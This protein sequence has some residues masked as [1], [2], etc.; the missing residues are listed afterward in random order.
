M[1][2]KVRGSSPCCILK[3]VIGFLDDYLNDSSDESLSDT[4]SDG[5]YGGGVG[6]GG[7]GSVVG[8][9]GGGGIRQWSSSSDEQ[10]S[11]LT[12]SLDSDFQRPLFLLCPKCVLLRSPSPERILLTCMTSR[13]KAICGKWHSLGSW[14]RAITG[15][16]RVTSIDRHFLLSP[17]TLPDYEH[18]RLFMILPPSE[19]VSVQDWYQLGRTRFFEGLEVHFLCENPGYWH[20]N[21]HCAFK[22]RASARQDNKALMSI[23]KMAVPLIQLI[24]GGSEPSQTSRI[25]APVVS[26]LMHMYDF[27][28]TSDSLNQV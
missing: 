14:N 8:G 19:S 22:I 26:D 20:M 10:V 28:S 23:F 6:G 21:E 24:Q 15:D 9:C 5:S 16:Y 27:L 17:S 12:E 7:V 11:Y 1:F 2:A 25:L 18:P 13:Q 4:V 3:A